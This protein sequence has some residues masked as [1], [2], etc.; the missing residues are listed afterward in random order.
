MTK[1]F[2]EE[3][4]R[5]E[6][7]LVAASHRDMREGRC[8]EGTEGNRAERQ[9]VFNSTSAADGRLDRPN[10]CKALGF[11]ARLEQF[12]DAAW[13]R[14]PELAIQGIKRALEHEKDGRMRKRLRKDL[15]LAEL[16]PDL[17]PRD[18]SSETEL[19]VDLLRRNLAAARADY[20]AEKIRKR[21]MRK[22]EQRNK[23]TAGAVSRSD[24]QQPEK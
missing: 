18:E 13:A 22:L 23:T 7:E 8:R 2:P 5:R 24:F 10:S 21:E 15:R 3:N 14:L 20:E 9:S 11:E 17:Q 12:R 16:P 6:P 19:I 4:P 1:R